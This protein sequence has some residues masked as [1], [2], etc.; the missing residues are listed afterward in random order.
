MP[1]F[2]CLGFFPPPFCFYSGKMS[3]YFSSMAFF[4]VVH[5]AGNF[6]YGAEQLCHTP[7]LIFIFVLLQK[8]VTFTVHSKIQVRV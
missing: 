7:C 1:R 2:D 5:F 6:A 3:V 8:N 4:F